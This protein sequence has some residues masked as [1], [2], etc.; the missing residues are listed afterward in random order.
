MKTYKKIF[1]ISLLLVILSIG[2]GAVSASQD[3]ATVDEL[4]IA[5]NVDIESSDINNTPIESSND[6]QQG[7]EKSNDDVLSSDGA[8]LDVKDAYTQ[9]NSFRTEQNVWQWN[10]DDTT[11]TVFNSNDANT[12]QPLSRDINLELTAKVRAKEIAQS[13][14]HTRPDGTPCYT[15][16]PSDLT[17]MGENIAYGQKSADEV[18]EAWKETNDPYAGQ[19]HRRN[20]LNSTYNCVGIAGYKVNGVIYWVQ[21]FGRSTNIISEE[22]TPKIIAKK[23]TYKAKKSK[24][25]SI[26]LTGGKAPVEKVKLTLKIGKKKFTATTNAK[27][28]ATFKIKLTKKGTYKGKITSKSTNFLKVGSKKVTIKIK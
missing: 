7:L 1:L 25:Y 18:T 28:K 9:L 3:N 13:F 20:M 2:A 17:A 12:L 21:N 19:G 5:E 14:S 11:K 8:Y 22:V 27:G 26:T 15:A 10:P 4:T 6:D 16:F 23:A 24:K